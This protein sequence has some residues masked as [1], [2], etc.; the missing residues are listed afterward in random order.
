MR[1]DILNIKKNIVF[2]GR[3][4]TAIYLILKSLKKN[5]GMVIFPANICYAAIYPA[6][7]AGY[8]IKLIDIDGKSGNIDCEELKKYI[9]TADVVVV[10][11]MYGNPVTYIEDISTLCKN[12]NVVLI[13][14]CAS[15]MGAKVKGKLCGTFGDYSIFSTGY[16]KTIDVGGGGFLVTDYPV[17]KI[18]AEYELIEE[19]SANLE[20]DE[21]FF[22]KLYRL[23]RNTPNQSLEK[24]IWYGLRDNLKPL[25]IYKD[26]AIEEKIVKAVDELPE[27][28]Q[29]RKKDLDLYH[30][31]LSDCESF[32]LYTWEHG[33]VPWRCNIL[34]KE[35][36]K[37]LISYLLSKNVPV[38]DWYPSVQNIFGI[39][40]VFENTKKMEEEILNFPLLIDEEEIV[41]ICKEIKNFY[42]RK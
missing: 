8:N 29:R 13:E 26:S 18:K 4:A 17:D 38:S 37:E 12:N 41:R 6:I 19:K 35:N 28:I 5:K 14:D 22:S 33:F 30:N 39:E 25:F 20:P 10:P 40:E 31:N 34:V 36:K 11:H 42:N 27:I 7:Y 21:A 23:I 1:S 16:S 9:H 32:S 3:A 15:A 2:T 24:Y